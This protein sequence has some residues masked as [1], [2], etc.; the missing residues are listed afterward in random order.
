MINAQESFFSRLRITPDYRYGF[1]IPHHSFFTYLIEDHVR[2]WDVT[3]SFQTKGDK[4]WQQLYRNP[5]LG[6]GYYHANLGNPKYLGKTDALFGYVDVPFVLKPNFKFSYKLGLGIAFMSKPF[7]VESN[8]YNTAIASRANAFV[9]IGLSVEQKVISTF[10]FTTGLK[11]THFSNGAWK[12]PNLGFNI[13]SVNAGIKYYFK[14]PESIVKKSKEEL[15]SLFKKKFEFWCVYSIGV[16]ENPPPNGKKYYPSCLTINTEKQ[17]ML[18]RKFGAGLDIF[19]D[20][21]IGAR[22]KDDTTNVYKSYNLRSGIHVSH[23][24]VFNKISFTMQVG[25]YFYTHEKR[26][27]EFLYSRFGLRVKLNKHIAATLTL[28]TH[29][30]KADIIEWGLGYYFEKEN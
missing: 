30:F 10:Y 13:P 24:L 28:K 23:D 27:D 22:H 3:C 5:E 17:F 21:S 9:D 15:K 25:T 19:Y 16:R 26:S 20:P 7:D 8:I 18:R 11:F 1:I 12:V 6:I 29:F 2:A 4:Y 14:K